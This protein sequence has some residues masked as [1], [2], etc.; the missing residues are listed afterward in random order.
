MLLLQ[1]SACRAMRLHLQCKRSRLAF[2][3]SELHLAALAS[4]AHADSAMINHPI[5]KQD[6]SK[7]A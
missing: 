6:V 7:V 3:F 2:S 1:L 5:R 4:I